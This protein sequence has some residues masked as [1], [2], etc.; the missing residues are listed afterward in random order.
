MRVTKAILGVGVAM[1]V[2]GAVVG[3]AYVVH[4][5]H[6]VVDGSW[7]DAYPTYEEMTQHA[8]AVVRGHVVRVIGTERNQAE[9]STYTDFAFQVDAWIAGKPMSQDITIHQMGGATGF[10]DVE[11]MGDPAL[12][13]GESD[14]L[15][16]RSYASGKYFIMGG[17]TGRLV[18][19]GGR[20]SNLPAG[21]L[22]TSGDVASVTAKVAGVAKAMGKASPAT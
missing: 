12:V 4:P 2:V 13:V 11:V 19:T 18:Q 8:D 5:L 1:T 21:L 14:L 3:G 20:L 10:T 15:F 17:P 22:R 9:S 7:A 16:L 6:E